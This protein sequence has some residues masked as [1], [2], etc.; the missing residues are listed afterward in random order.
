MTL[1]LDGLYVP[2][3]IHLLELQVGLVGVS[4]K[5]IKIQIAIFTPTR[6]RV[7]LCRVNHSTPKLLHHNLNTHIEGFSF[8]HWGNPNDHII[9][10]ITFLVWQTPCERN[11][12]Y[13]R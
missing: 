10:P 2:V 9:P 12:L 3:G 1:P 4:D 7:V 5:N 6:A 13:P 11:F 8:T